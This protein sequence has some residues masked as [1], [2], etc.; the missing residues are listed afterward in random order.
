MPENNDWLERSWPG[1]VV[2]FGQIKAHIGQFESELGLT[3]AEVAEIEAFMAYAISVIN[4]QTDSQAAAKGVTEWRDNAFNGPKGQPLPAP[5]AANAYVVP[6]G[7]ETGIIEIIREWREQWVAADGYEQ[8]IGETLMIVKAEGDSLNPNDVTPTIQVSG[9]QSGY[10][11]GI[12]VSDRGDAK[13]SQVWI[14][15]KGGE[16]TLAETLEGKGGSITITPLTPG[17][18]EQVDVRVQLRKNNA[19]YGNVSATHTV[20]VNP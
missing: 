14:R 13:I 19:N 12:I 10:E 9:A 4:H 3:P 16:W 5:P 2:Q 18:P 6:A 8:A 1:R 11:I 15:Q 17:D 7:A 20:T